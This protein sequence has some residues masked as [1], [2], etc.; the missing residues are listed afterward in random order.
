MIAKESRP[1][2]LPW[3]LAAVAAMMLALNPD[4]DAFF[5]AIANFTFFIC[6]AILCSM[7]FGLEFQQRTFQLLLV[8]PLSRSRQWG[9]KMLILSVAVATLGLLRWRIE[10]SAI[11][12]LGMQLFVVGF[13]L[14]SAVCSAGVWIGRRGSIAMGVVAGIAAVI[15]AAKRLQYAHG[16]WN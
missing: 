4:L 14:L 12:L 16:V 6:V 11:H 10:K 3:C 15:T 13:F 5:P 1:L 8:Q 9:D 2:V 7:T